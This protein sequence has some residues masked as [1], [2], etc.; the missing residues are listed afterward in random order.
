LYLFLR[1]NAIA[2]QEEEDVDYAMTEEQ[3]QVKIT[4]FKTK[5]PKFAAV[6]AEIPNLDLKETVKAC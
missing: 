1:K 6:I 2:Q 3:I 4:D 5:H